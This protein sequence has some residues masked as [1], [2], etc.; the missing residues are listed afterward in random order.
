MGANLDAL[1][2]ILSL[3]VSGDT[4]ED[5]LGRLER[6]GLG[7]LEQLEPLGRR[8]RK[9]GRTR[10]GRRKEPTTTITSTIATIVMTTMQKIWHCHVVH[11]NKTELQL[12]TNH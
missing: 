12:Q 8:G 7:R 1:L 9:R 2:Y 3:H 4:E 11:D 5:K 6:L 10:R